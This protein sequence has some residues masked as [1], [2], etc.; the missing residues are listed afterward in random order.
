MNQ[1]FKSLSKKRHLL[2]PIPQTCTFDVHLCHKWKLTEYVNMTNGQ[3][4]K[5]KYEY[6]TVDIFHYQLTFYRK[7]Y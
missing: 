6:V 7:N 1:L 3:I 5:I 2:V 4:N